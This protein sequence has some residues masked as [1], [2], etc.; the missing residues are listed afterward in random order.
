MNWSKDFFQNDAVGNVVSTILIIL[1]SYAIVVVLLSDYFSNAK[2]K[3]IHDT[4]KL[5]KK[6][7]WVGKKLVSTHQL[8]D[9]IANSSATKRKV[10]FI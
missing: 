1:A 10:H 4:H 6:K 8:E 2:T 3:Y 9:N 5:K 7:H